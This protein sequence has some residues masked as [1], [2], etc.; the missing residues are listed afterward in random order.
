MHHVIWTL[1]LIGSIQQPRHDHQQIYRSTKLF[2]LFNDNSSQNN[3][4][5]SSVVCTRVLCA[6]S[7]EHV[8]RSS[9]RPDD[10]TRRD[11]R[12]FI[13]HNLLQDPIVFI[14]HNLHKFRWINTRVYN[15]LTRSVAISSCSALPVSGDITSEC[16]R[17]VWCC[18]ELNPD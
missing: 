8:A 12:L 5:D 13:S 16:F 14:S 3:T 11:A 9:A 15:A 7:A 17:R 10:V 2:I 4:H 1:T 18:R 6:V